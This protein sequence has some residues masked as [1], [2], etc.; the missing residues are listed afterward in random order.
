MTKFVDIAHVEPFE[1]GC[2][3]SAAV[4]GSSVAVFNVDGKLYA[5]DDVCIRCGSSLAKGKLQG[6]VVTCGTCHW[7]YH[8]VTGHVNDLPGMHVDRFEEKMVDGHI[9]LCLSPLP[10][11]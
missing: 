6:P 10:N 2:A 1:P 3:T 4:A 8:V 11:S 5:T 7:R 9:V